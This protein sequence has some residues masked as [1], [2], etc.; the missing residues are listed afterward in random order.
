MAKSNEPN[1]EFFRNNRI[2]Q[3]KI[4][5][6]ED[7]LFKIK[8]TLRDFNSKTRE[9]AIQV[10][11]DMGTLPIVRGRVGSNDEERTLE[12]EQEQLEHNKYVLKKRGP[13]LPITGKRQTTLGEFY[14]TKQNSKRLRTEGGSKKRNQKRKSRTMKKRK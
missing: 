5:E 13:L 10:F 8:Q 11:G 3:Q 14:S 9:N 12:N 4:Y 7:E 1:N 6:I 2:I